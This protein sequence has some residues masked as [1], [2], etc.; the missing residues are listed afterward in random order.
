[1]DAA[2]RVLVVGGG[3]IGLS[4]AWRLARA[5][6]RVE[7]LDASGSRG[8]SWVAAG[9]LAPVSEAAFGE[10]A[11]LRLNLAALERFPH[12]AAEIERDARQDAGLHREGS[13]LVAADADDWAALSRASAF[14]ASLGLTAETLTASRRRRLEPFLSPGV[15]G[16]ILVPGDLSVDNRRYLTAL[17]AAASAAGVQRRAG[18]A[19]SL[20]WADGHVTG[21][22]TGDA[23]LL[24]GTVVLA[25]GS[26]TG[27]IGGLPAGLLVPVRPV[28]GQLLRLGP[29]PVPGYSG[30]PIRHTIRALVRGSEVYL[31]PRSTGEVVVGATMEEQGHDTTVTAGAVHDLLRDACEV[32]PALRELALAECLAG[33]R[34]G[35]PDNGPLVGPTGTPG[36]VLATGHYRNGILLS[37]LT[38]DAV[39]AAVTG[40]PLAPEWSPFTPSRFTASSA[41]QGLNDDLSDGVS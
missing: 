17:A 18:C 27:E 20:L 34:P 37:A 22:R 12:A 19:R 4:A 7:V 39:L 21:V 26:R 1:V 35:T 8:A 28:K 15:R 24:A 33:S 14:R 16:A 5:G 13:L 3:V 32:V 25:A 41:A 11:L 29:S 6:H 30:A 31:A 23:D 36:L 40:R 9:M 2:E 38:G 10:E